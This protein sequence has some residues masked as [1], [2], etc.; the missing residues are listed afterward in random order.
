MKFTWVL[1]QNCFLET[2]KEKTM[3]TI[4]HTAS[5]N[6]L[7][8]LAG[9]KN[10]NHTSNYSTTEKV[11]TSKMLEHKNWLDSVCPLIII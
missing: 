11:A 4:S 5:L 8:L 3:F 2:I 6:L 1:L 10:T 7:V 9:C